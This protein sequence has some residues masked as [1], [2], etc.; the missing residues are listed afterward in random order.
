MI[1]REQRGFTLVELL[2][3]IT[4]IAM[5]MALLIPVVGRARESARRT[6]CMNNQ[7]EIGKAMMLYAT[8]QNFMPPYLTMQTD[9]TVA[10]P[11]PYFLG[12]AQVLMSQLGRDDLAIGKIINY[13]N[14]FVSG[15]NVKGPNLAILICPDDA[16]KIGA[17]NGPLTYVVNGGATNNYSPQG[18]PVN[19]SA[20]GAW[21]YRII[22]VTNNG[23]VPS[24]AVNH[25]SIDYIAKHDGAATTISHSENLDATSYVAPAASQANATSN[26][27]QP[28]QC[29]IW[30]PV[31]A[32][33]GQ[34]PVINQGIGTN[35]AR[36]SSN[37]PGGAVVTFC[38]GH[39]AFIADSI[40]YYVYALLMT[41]YGG[42][43]FA[44]GKAPPNPPTSDLYWKF[45]NDK[46]TNP[47]YPL[48][49]NAIP[50]N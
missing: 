26:A 21:D 32:S 30:D 42:Q 43:S 41:S 2:V 15:P 44:P 16:T 38:D 29:F 8:T 40:N 31:S 25:T 17:T 12:W 46:N 36:P 20:N 35:L 19:W 13:G 3:V 4:I 18:L 9:N 5:L 39:V 11:T 1:R 6:T 23:A 33:V 48:D 27:I 24:A 49:G 50:T 47:A 34:S 10:T 22:I 45:Q 28:Q 37:H 7:T 14:T